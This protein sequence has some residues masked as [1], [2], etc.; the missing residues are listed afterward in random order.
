MSSATPDKQD[1]RPRLAIGHVELLVSDVGPAADL[2][3]KLGM[4]HIF[5]KDDFAVLELRGGT[6]LVLDKPDAPVPQGQEASFDLMVDDIQGMRDRC[7]SLGLRPSPI[8]TGRVHSSF[9]IVGPDGYK[10]EVNSSHASGE[11]V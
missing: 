1:G 7:E 9:S 11:P 5:Q 4:R 6:H 10:I 2:F 8:T 3:V